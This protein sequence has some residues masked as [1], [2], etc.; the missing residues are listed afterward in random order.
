LSALLGRSEAKVKKI[1]FSY[2]SFNAKITI[3]DFCMDSSQIKDSYKSIASEARGLFKDN[4]SRFIAHAY[5]VETEEE[6]KEI[7]A[8]L[9][10]E[11][12]DA[13][14]HVYAY[15]LGH[16]GDK[17]RA[18][19]DGE[20]SGSSGRPVLGQIDSNELSDILVVVVRY[21]GG[22]KLGIPG[23]I[24]AYKT[25]T[26]DALANAEIVE[27]IASKRYRISFGYMN[28]N[29]VMKVMKDMG[30]EQKNQKFDMECSI[31]TNVRL[32][33]VNTFLERMGDVEGC[34]ID[35]I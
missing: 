27:K 7:V 25:S 30:L 35:E 17:F 22:I 18:N 28:M 5:P 24:R 3:F 23:L 11:Y 29:D 21:F 8:A 15:R 14:H 34:S 4:G 26:A 32:S 9:K 20:P 2:F 16:L 1:F 19:D 31:D 13:R 6:V 10:K 33:Q 12:Y